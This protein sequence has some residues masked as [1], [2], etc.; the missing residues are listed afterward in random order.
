MEYLK[1]DYYK[2]SRILKV[3]LTV[4]QWAS[5]LSFSYNLGFGN[6]DNLVPNINAKN[7][8]ALKTQWVLYKYA[9]GKEDP[10]LLVRRQKELR[11]F[12]LT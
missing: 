6:G 4:N 11:N 5:L 2:F 1:T 7:W 10:D 3:P 12:F 8:S 9:D